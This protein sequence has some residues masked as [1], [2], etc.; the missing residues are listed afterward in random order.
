[1]LIHSC[2]TR[3]TGAAAP[4]S[5]AIADGTAIDDYKAERS[6]AAETS[7]FKLDPRVYSVVS[8]SI[9]L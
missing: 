6:G 2:S 8:R 4:L 9:A 5:Y 7:L 1:M 3:G